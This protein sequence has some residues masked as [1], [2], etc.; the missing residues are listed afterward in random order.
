MRRVVTALLIL[1]LAVPF[2]AGC[3]SRCRD[4]EIRVPNTKYR[5]IVDQQCYPVDYY[6][7]PYPKAR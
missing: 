1:S 7:N 3:A 6:G 2:L 5:T 4:H